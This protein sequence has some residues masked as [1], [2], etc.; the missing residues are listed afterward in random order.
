MTFNYWYMRMFLGLFNSS[1]LNSWN[2]TKWFKHSIKVSNFPP[3]YSMGFFACHFILLWHLHLTF[4]TLGLKLDTTSYII[5][6]LFF[7]FTAKLKQNRRLTTY[8]VVPACYI[9]FRHLVL[10]IVLFVQ[11]LLR[12]RKTFIVAKLVVTV[13]MSKVLKWLHDEL[14]HELFLAEEHPWY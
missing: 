7:L 9:C 4:F 5:Y 14:T 3:K 10:K 12:R 11:V 1:T 8:D 2:L 6:F 13:G